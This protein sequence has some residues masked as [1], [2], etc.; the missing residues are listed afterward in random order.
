MSYNQSII[1]RNR[2]TMRKFETCINTNDLAL[3]EKLISAS[4]A[5]T[6]PVSPEP[7]YGAKGYL[8]VVVLMRESF[9]D[10]QWKLVDMVA[11]EKTVAVQWLCS[12]PLPEQPRLRG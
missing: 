5:F 10:V 7:L 6:T 2:E 11:D 9:P 3:G 12:E 4:A 1:E 8:S